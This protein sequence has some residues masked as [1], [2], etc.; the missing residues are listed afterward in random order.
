MMLFLG[1]LLGFVLDGKNGK[2]YNK[3]NTSYAIC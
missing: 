3:L 2:Y 1:Y